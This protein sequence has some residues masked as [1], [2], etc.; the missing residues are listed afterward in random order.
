M[1]HPLEVTTR[2]GGGYKV[3]GTGSAYLFFNAKTESGFKCK[4]INGNPVIVELYAQ[5]FV[6]RAP[7]RENTP[8]VLHGLKA[9]RSIKSDT[10]PPQKL[11]TVRF[12]RDEFYAQNAVPM[13]DE[14]IMQLYRRV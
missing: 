4:D 1:G 12:D 14:K 2:F 11:D 10:K 7:L 9:V 3:V 13:D 5:V 6:L 8:A